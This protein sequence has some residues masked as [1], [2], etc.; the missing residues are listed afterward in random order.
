[1]K[2]NRVFKLSV[3]FAVFLSASACGAAGQAP[4]TVPLLEIEPT[5]LR[6]M[7]HDSFDISEEILGSFE[8]E[9]NA[10]VT[11]LPSGDAGAVLNQAILAGD[12]PL[13]D[14]IF[15]VD[16]TFL[17][18]A[19]DSG[20]LIP[21]QS[22]SLDVVPEE[23]RLDPS[24]Q[25]TPVDFGDVCLNY[26]ISWF[27]ENGIEPPTS[28]EDLAAIDYRGLTVVENPASSSPGMA[29]LLATIH[30]FSSGGEDAY[31]DYWE[32][33]VANDVL[34]TEGWE[35]AYWGHFSAAS[36]GDRPIVVS[37]ASS[38]PAEIYYSDPPL[39]EPP[40]AVVV[41]NGSCFRQ[42]EFA[43]ILRG[44]EQYELATRFIDFMLSREFQEDIP[45]NMFVFPVNSEAKLP[46]IFTRWAVLPEE[47]D[48]LSADEI[49]AG[50]DR[51]IRDW[52][53]QV[54]R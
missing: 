21:Y 31:L 38:P 46:E 30:R 39:D 52:T 10:R 23:F 19:I 29:F 26:D 36:D 18:R 1:M 13:A 16:N 2:W 9:H 54:L 48:Q 25:L 45:L 50:R 5:E 15:G 12:E 7:T 4:S 51:W 22:P 49:D 17:G 33:L 3:A 40:T 27:D 53:E 32:S 8:A 44:T 41:G 42:I 11:V 6:L 14:I 20:I 37:Y 34:I 47:I 28:L 35:E 43:G 24:H